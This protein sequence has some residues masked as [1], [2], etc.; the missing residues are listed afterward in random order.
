MTRLELLRKYHHKA[1]GDLFMASDNYLM[2]EP[3]PGREEEW[4]AAQEE[5]VMF[6]QWIKELGGNVYE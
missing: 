4:Q 3:K 1:C 2:D 6:E 5:V